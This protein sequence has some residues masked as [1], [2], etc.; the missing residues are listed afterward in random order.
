MSTLRV[1][2]AGVTVASLSIPAF[3]LNTGQ[4]VNLLL[5]RS[6]FFELIPVLTG[7]QVVSGFQVFGRSI[8]AEPASH[9]RNIFTLLRHGRI[10]QPTPAEWLRGRATHYSRVEAEAVVA[11]LGLRPQWR[12]CQLAGNP[13]MLLGLEAAWAQGA[14]IV[15]F[16]T[17][18]C[19][20]RG[21]Q[22]VFD[23]VASRLGQ[24]AVIYLSTVYV[25]N[26]AEG[27]N[28]FPGASS[29][30]VTILPS[31]TGRLTATNLPG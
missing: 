10:R 5:P 22:L 2:C 24:C 23:A 7:Q 4:A 29:V 28:L 11:R 20:P 21:V 27:R 18:G 8:W 31:A 1:S 26:G 13:R 17:V 30:D 9:P 16:G 14:D 6:A 25:S 19:D 15:V 3:Q 12:L